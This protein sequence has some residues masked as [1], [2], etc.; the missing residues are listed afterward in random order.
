MI[1]LWIFLEL[2]R[3][4][5]SFSNRIENQPDSNRLDSIQ[6]IMPFCVLNGCGA[7]CV[8]YVAVGCRWLHLLPKYYPMGSRTITI[9]EW[10][11]LSSRSLASTT[12][13]KFRTHRVGRQPRWHLLEM[14][15]K[16]LPRRKK[17]GSALHLI[18]NCFQFVFNFGAEFTSR[19]LEKVMRKQF[20]R[21][22]M[23]RNMSIKIWASNMV[24]Y[25]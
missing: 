8:A 4:F 23:H 25:A 22:Q 20:K 10:W 24:K 12:F 14:I 9:F 3:T 17:T 16:E 7:I 5:S 15:C 6:W 18:R 21:V 2:F 19:K 13:R 1:R 11:L